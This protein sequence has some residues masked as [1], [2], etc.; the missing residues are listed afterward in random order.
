MKPL[1]SEAILFILIFAN[2]NSPL[3]NTE[4]PIMFSPKNFIPSVAS[5]IPSAIP[6]EEPTAWS[7]LAIA[8][9]HSLP[10][11]CAKPLTV[12]SSVLNSASISA[13]PLRID[14]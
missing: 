9:V 11:T 13:A 8:L 6:A 2:K 12:A 10:N 4:K 3:N 1:I 5:L 7:K 14:A